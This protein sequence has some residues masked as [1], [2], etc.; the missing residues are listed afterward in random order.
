MVKKQ[1][2]NLIIF[3]PFFDLQEFLKNRGSS[4]KLSEYDFCNLLDEFFHIVEK[5]TSKKQSYRF[6]LK[7]PY[8][9]CNLNPNQKHLAY[10]QE[11]QKAI[12]DQSQ[13]IGHLLFHS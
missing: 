12:F 10:Q 5:H 13:N 6:Y 3:G 2:N 1:R 8:N 4:F 9:F 7:V 11:D